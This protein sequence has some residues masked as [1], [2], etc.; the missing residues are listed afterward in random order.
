M[1]VGEFLATVA[2]A[3]FAIW[4]SAQLYDYV[5][6]KRGKFPRA[7]RTT[8]SDIRR[9]R[10]EGHIGIAVKRFQQMPENKGLYTDQGAEKKVKDL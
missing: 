9:L 3:T 10:D 2:F 1:T 4:G 6:V 5:Q 7:S 8:L